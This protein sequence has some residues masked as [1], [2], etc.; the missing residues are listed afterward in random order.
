[1]KTFSLILFLALPAIAFAQQ[2]P[3][4]TFQIHID[5][6]EY[7]MGTGP[8][9]CLDSAHHNF[10]TL[11]GGYIAFA[12]IVRKD[13]YRI[14]DFNSKVMSTESLKDC[15]IFMVVI[16]LHES[17]TNGNWQLP[18]PSA[19]TSTEI[20][21]IHKWVEQGGSFFLIADHMPFAGAAHDLGK[22]F[23]FEYSNGFARFGPEQQ[24]PET[25]TLENGRLLKSPV[26]GTGITSVI[27][28]TG[29]AFTFPD[30]A[31]PIMVFKEE[32]VSLEPEIAWEFNDSTKTVSL[33]G[34]SQGAIMDYGQGRLAVFGEAAMFTAQIFPTDQGPYKFGLNNQE[35]A[36]QN[37]DFL[38]NIMHWLDK[39]R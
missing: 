14:S 28:F 5:N 34:Y 3:D 36:P 11:E 25:F 13:G 16:P 27:S 23:G 17:N 33:K 20:G 1:M 10:H 37:I 32:D 8:M 12:R 24:S 9:I 30:E 21:S 29:S 39:D 6:P 35:V 18:T 38:L 19:F 22:S 31:K 7:D 26:S 2:R 15:D 4:T